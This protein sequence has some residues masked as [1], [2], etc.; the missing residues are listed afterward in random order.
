MNTCKGGASG[1]QQKCWKFQAALNPT[2]ALEQAHAVRLT[3]IHPILTLGLLNFSLTQFLAKVNTT[4]CPT[5][6]PRI[7]LHLASDIFKRHTSCLKFNWCISHLLVKATSRCNLSYMGSTRSNLLCNSP[8]TKLQIGSICSTLKAYSW[9]SYRGCSQRFQNW[10]FVH[11]FFA[12]LPEV[13]FPK[14]I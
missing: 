1:N 5:Y 14:G 13:H 2:K 6:Y 3:Y 9:I 10:N 4:N 12:F 7:K 8:V 11:L